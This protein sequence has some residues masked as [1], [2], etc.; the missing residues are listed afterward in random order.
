MTTISIA[1]T[2]YN[3]A[4]FLEQQLRSFAEQTRLPDELVI[5]DDGSTDETGAITERF[6][7]SAPFPVRFL[8]D[9][10]KLGVQMNFERAVRAATGDLLFMSDHDDIWFPE[11]LAVVEA[12][13]AADA[14]ALTIVNDQVIADAE[15][16]PTGRTVLENARRLG[17]GDAALGTGACT[18][19][20]RE[21]LPVLLPFPGDAVPYDH[22][23]NSLPLLLGVRRVIERPLQLYRRHG[24][25]VTASLL[26]DAGANTLSLVTARTGDRRQAYRR[27]I[28]GLDLQRERLEDRREAL[29]ALGLA[30]ASER[31][32]SELRAQ[33]D[34]TE[35]RLRA[36]SRPRVARPFLVARH[37]AAGRYRRFQG[38]RSA[39]KD[40]V[41]P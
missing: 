19:L 32:V 37:L 31:A 11:K 35:A 39:A 3:S 23:T 6:A 16:R 27:Q 38:W 8:H 20:R 13:F 25:N 1:M 40:I 24:D 26:A 15:C 12:A 29:A 7:R 22:W 41:A 33:R 30:E 21:I 28:A 18:A 14:G 36:I 17:Y 34:D 9:H 4:R 10:P 2:S 5:S